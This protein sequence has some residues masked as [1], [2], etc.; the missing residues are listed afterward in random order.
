MKMLITNLE[1]QCLFDV[2]IETQTEGL[3]TL[4]EGKHKKTELEDYLKGGEIKIESTDPCE[5]CE[6]I[7]EIIKGAKKHGKVFIAFDGK[8]LGPLLNF[9]ANRVGVDG[10]FTC[11]KNKVVRIPMLTLDL[12]ATKIDILKNLFQEDL[13][14]LQ[15]VEKVKISRAMVYKHIKQLLQ[16][17][18]VERSQFYEKYAITQSGKL[19]I[20]Y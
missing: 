7:A 17:G 12:S 3:I 11:Y 1:G 13:T 9:V 19:A 2:S 16:L 4:H 15:I 6:K 5:T 18:L 20:T 14:A 8:G 10:I